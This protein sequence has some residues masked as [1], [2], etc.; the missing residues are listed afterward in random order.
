MNRHLIKA[1]RARSSTKVRNP[2]ALYLPPHQLAASR[3]NVQKD[4]EHNL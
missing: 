4:Y 3:N 2:Q 1:K